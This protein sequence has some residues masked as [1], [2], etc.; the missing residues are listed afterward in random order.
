MN[1]NIGEKKFRYVGTKAFSEQENTIFFGRDEEIKSI[2]QLVSLENI[3]IIHSE[4]GYG[5]SSLLNAG[6]IPIF[7]KSNSFEI[8][9]VRF[10]IPSEIHKISPLKALQDILKTFKTTECYI[11]KLISEETTWTILKKIQNAIDDQKTLL[12]I[13]DQ[14]EEFF[15]FPEIEQVEFFK[16]I[17]SLF[18]EIIPQFEKQIIKNTLENSKN[19]L[20]E[21]GNILLYKKVDLKLVFSLKSDFIPKLSQFISLFPDLIKNV[22][23]LQAMSHKQAEKAIILPA[24]YIAKYDSGSPFVSDCFQFSEQTI[25]TILDYLDDNKNNLIEPY[26]LQIICAFLE[27]RVIEENIETIEITQKE[28]IADIYQNY[29]KHIISEIGNENEQLAAKIFIEEGLILETEN[30]KLSLYE[31]LVF[32]RYNISRDLLDKLLK[33]RL[34]K[35]GVNSVNETFY[36]LSHETLVQP[37]LKS[38]RI[39]LNEVQR[40][41]DE[42]TKA[43]RLKESAEVQMK[44]AKKIKIIAS[45][46]FVAM[47]FLITGTILINN[48]RK[49]AQQNEA[50]AKSNLFAAYSYQ[51]SETDPTVSFRLAE[52]AYN[53][54]KTN[55]TAI[56]ALINSYYSTETFYS[57]L[58]KTG[59]YTVSAKI[60]PDKKSILTNNSDRNTNKNSISLLDLQ[61]NVKFQFDQ[62]FPITCEGFSPDGKFIFSGDIKGNVLIHDS[63]GKLIKKMKVGE[64]AVW[65]I[66]YS[67]DL[68]NILTSSGDGNIILWSTIND[69]SIKLP[70]HLYDVYSIDISNDGKF[71]LTADDAEIHICDFKGNLIKK[72]E[73]PAQKSY[74]FPFIQSVKFSNDSKTILV[75]INDKTGK[76]HFTRLFDIDGNILN[77]YRGHLDWINFAIFS[78]DGQKILTTSRDKTIKIKSIKGDDLGTLKGHTSNILD[79]TFDQ[80]SNSII[81]VGDDKNIYKWNFG[82]FLNPLAEINDIDNAMFSPDG[83]KIYTVNKNEIHAFDQTGQLLNKF[84]G[85]TKNIEVF[86]ISNDGNRICAASKDAIIKIWDNNAT[87]ISTL[88]GHKGK[89]KSLIF[90]KDSLFILSGATDSLIILW[91]IQTKQPEHIYKCKAAI[92]SVCLSVDGNIILTAESTGNLVLRNMQGVVIRT[93]NAHESQANSASFSL[94]GKYIIS[95]GADKVAMIYTVDG[96]LINEL[97]NYKSMINSA[98]FS[99]DSKNILISGEDGYVRIFTISG[100]E[101]IRL[102]HQ[103][104]V[105]NAKY[106]S[107]GKFII[108]IYKDLNFKT[109]KMWVID[110]EKILELTNEVK[111]FGN[112]KQ[113]DKSEYQIYSF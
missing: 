15:Y 108:S 113:I 64:S 100:K 22:F 62:E 26:K 6:L 66:L 89:I 58:G 25:K 7:R 93:I 38:K 90:T 85:Q 111:I 65:S 110:P 43:E 5:K 27:Q 104:K 61:G 102:K 37:I 1:S 78:N 52:H 46:V 56:S 71:I 82:R 57:C 51:E 107:D 77:D 106:S 103:G 42:L 94:D 83:L 88:K 70:L 23:E 80:N 74:Y 20:T 60:S 68:K 12:I 4:S 24:K 86:N 39:R 30:K 98:E 48:S 109:A 63:F 11:D 112:F 29:Y 9:K 34:I 84:I 21:Q 28:Q 96:Q 16:S 105:S 18:K 92:N 73:L 44:A 31:G 55:L 59:K 3:T 79:A 14:F 50:L 53:L 32:S 47:L 72:I 91:N 19:L 40:I 2:F 95:T 87:E 67:P 41:K 35:A 45:L 17:S 33:S 36:E 75:V 76:N 69:S 54:D 8:F 10:V 101:L 81:S 13:F 99:A 97:S 49:Q